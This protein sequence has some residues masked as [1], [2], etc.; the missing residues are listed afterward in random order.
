MDIILSIASMERTNYSAWNLLAASR[1]GHQDW[2]AAWRDASPKA[3]LRR[4]HVRGGS[5]RLTTAYYL[6]RNHGVTN[7]TVELLGHTSRIGWWM[8]FSVWRMQTDFGTASPMWSVPSTSRVWDTQLLSFRMLTADDQASLWRWLHLAL[9][10]PPP[11]P[12]R[13]IEV[14]RA[15]GARIYVEGWGRESDVGVVAVVD[16]IDAGACWMRVLPPGTGLASVDAHTPQL[17]IA[18]EPGYQHKGHGRPLMQ[19]ALACATRAGYAQVALTVHPENPARF[20]YQ[21]C[22]FQQVEVRN[23][24]WLM[25]ARVK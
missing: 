23:N 24:Y 2:A 7:I 5:H 3:T 4:D 18:L 21:S 22:G 25:V 6:A 1:L 17:G 13:P 10:D 14:L 15:P 20:L 16:G 19:E 8:P 12:P 11:A 9:W